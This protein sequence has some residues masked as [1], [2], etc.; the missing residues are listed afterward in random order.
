MVLLEIRPFR[1]GFDEEIYGR[2]FNAAFVDYDD[3]R[4]VTLHEV[5]T[6]EEAPSYNLDG[7]LIAEWN[8]QTA[9]MVQAFVDK[10][11]EE[12][13]GFIQTLAVLP[14][15]RRRGIARALVAKAIASLKERG[16]EVASA[17][18]QTD[19]SACMHLYESYGFKCVRA[20]SLMKGSLTEGPPE[21]GG[22]ES[23]CLRE[24][25][26]GED[27]EIALINRLDN[28]AFKEHFN[29]R[30]MRFEETRYQLLENPWFQD[31]KAWFAVVEHKP[32]GFVVAGIDVGLNREKGVKCGWILT[33]GVLKPY[34]RKGAGSTLMLQAM[35]YL[36]SLEMEN[37]L[38]YVD[39]E[40]PT[41]AIKLYEKVGFKVFHKNAVYELRLL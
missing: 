32:V 20:M 40:N 36:K 37:A 13:K 29:H 33:I 18:V 21:V 12:K 38:L 39:D 15:F 1:K 35:R 24:A 8:G 26:I 16:M 19:R 23:V 28:E 14:E 9:G 30:P 22:D 5:R 31:K 11:R 27:E 2:I 34:R 10:F 17:W 41:C 4:S 6:L 25:R 3:V 7:L